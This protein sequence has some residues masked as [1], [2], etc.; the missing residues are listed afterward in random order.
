MG[1]PMRGMVQAA[2]GSS[3]LMGLPVRGISRLL[4]AM[5]LLIPLTGEPHGAGCCHQQPH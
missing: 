3:L 1:S 2:D 5:Q 4:M